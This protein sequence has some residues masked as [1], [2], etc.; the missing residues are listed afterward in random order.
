LS[1]KEK[2]VLIQKIAYALDFA[3]K[4]KI[5][6]RDIK[7]SN[8]LVRTNGEPVLMDFGIAKRLQSNDASLTK[9]GDIVGT[10]QYMA[11]E[12]ASGLR[13]AV[14]YRSDIYSLG[15]VLYHLLTGQPPV[16]GNTMMEILYE[17]SQHKMLPAHQVNAAIPKPVSDLCA[18]AMAADKKD[19]YATAREFGDDIRSYLDGL[20]TKASIFVQRQRQK[21]W[22]R[23]VAIAIG[24]LLLL[25]GIGYGLIYWSSIAQSVEPQIK[26]WISKAHVS[27]KQYKLAQARDELLNA[28]ALCQHDSLSPALQQKWKENIA[29]NAAEISYTLGIYE[30][31]QNPLQ[32]FAYFYEAQDIA[33]ALRQ[34]NFNIKARIEIHIRYLNHDYAGVLKIFAKFSEPYEKVGKGREYL[35]YTYPEIFYILAKISYDAM[36]YDRA[37]EYLRTL[38][39]LSKQPSERPF[40]SK[41]LRGNQEIAKLVSEIGYYQGMCAFY[42]ENYV[43]AG[44]KLNASQEALKKLNIA[45][46]P[47]YF[48]L[49][50]HQAASLIR[51]SR[52]LEPIP[53]SDYN[54]VQQIYLELQ[55]HPHAIEQDLALFQEIRLRLMLTQLHQNPHSSKLAE[56][57]LLLSQECLQQNPFDATYYLFRGE[58]YIRLGKYKEAQQDIEY[59]SQLNPYQLESLAKMVDIASNYF[60]VSQ[61]SMEKLIGMIRRFS[62]KLESQT[63]DL[64]GND[65]QKIRAALQ[66]EFQQHQG[67]EFDQEKAAKIYQNIFSELEPVRLLAQSTLCSMQPSDRCLAFLKQKM[68]MLAVDKKAKLE[69]LIQNVQDYE[70]QRQ[71]IRYLRYLLLIP[72][73]NRIPEKTLLDCHAYLSF[74][75]F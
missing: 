12:Q 16:A 15:A 57:I 39:L 52:L 74:C 8:I 23:H 54:I 67:M 10:I 42:H 1:L 64:L 40:F 45:D 47:F 32:A 75:L 60:D 7:P 27:A 30:V 56:D 28:W 11:P 59:A 4:K 13:R 25:L 3:H 24:G 53:A 65:L 37:E 48:S 31:M 55:N 70:A 26:E 66:S 33:S 58:A 5:L 49:L 14:D 69:Q 9:S 34:D 6:H 71:Q 73:Q 20:S 63:S 46:T 19:R 21:S 61:N 41:E 18:K 50:I 17:L 68:D 72:Y 36:E 22:L 51:Q 29:Q 43:D 44:Q 2:L 38:A 62:M 35:S